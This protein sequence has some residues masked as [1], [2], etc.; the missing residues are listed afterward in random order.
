MFAFRTFFFFYF[1]CVNFHVLVSKVLG[2]YFVFGDEIRMGKNIFA[3]VL[4]STGFFSLHYQLLR[5]F[6]VVSRVLY[7]I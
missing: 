5:T 4:A 3:N 2:L 7:T 1:D 6:V